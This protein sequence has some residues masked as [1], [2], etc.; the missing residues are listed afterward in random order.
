M[1]NGELESAREHPGTGLDR[2]LSSYWR[3]QIRRVLSRKQHPPDQPQAPAEAQPGPPC[4]LLSHE[5]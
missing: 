5:S 4:S 3:G 2:V 1:Q